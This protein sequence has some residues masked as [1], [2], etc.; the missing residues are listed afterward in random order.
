MLKLSLSTLEFIVTLL[1]L[2]LCYLT[3][4]FGMDPFKTLA[5]VGTVLATKA[6]VRGY[7]IGKVVQASG[8]AETALANLKEKE[9]EDE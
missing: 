7:I 5:V 9:L 2:G 8:V 1:V 3:S 4:F 6:W